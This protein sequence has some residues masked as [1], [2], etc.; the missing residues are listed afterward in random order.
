MNVTRA[1]LIGLHPLTETSLIVRW[2]T[3]DEGLL[4]TA[5]KGARRPASPFRGKLDLFFE[6]EISVARS[7]KSTLQTL[8]EVSV[9]NPRVAL[10]KKYDSTLAASYFVRLIEMSSERETPIPEQHDLLGRALDYLCREVPDRR[11]VYHFEKQLA[12]IVGLAGHGNPRGAL[13]E[14]FGNLPRQRMELLRRL[15]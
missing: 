8:R 15:K 7:R 1:T 13:A 14:L 10:R 3:P 6:A 2:C 11:A 12:S 4:D 9:L 5:A